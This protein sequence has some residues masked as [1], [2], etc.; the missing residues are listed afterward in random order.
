MTVYFLF[1][2]SLIVFKQSL[3]HLSLDYLNRETENE[4][5]KI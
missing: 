4:N 1:F 5:L 2:F 3:D